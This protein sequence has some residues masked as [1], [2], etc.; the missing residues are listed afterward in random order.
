MKKAYEFTVQEMKIIL[1]HLL[2]EKVNE[3]I[4]AE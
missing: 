1:K 4:N 3:S 2:A